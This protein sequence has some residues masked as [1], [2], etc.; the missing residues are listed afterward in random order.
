MIILVHMYLVLQFRV[1]D[2]SPVSITVSTEANRSRSLTT[3]ISRQNEYSYSKVTSMSQ[4]KKSLKKL[5]YNL[6]EWHKNRKV[7]QMLMGKVQ[8]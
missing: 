2:I 6:N 8:I 5:L 1:M 7:V 3:Q 4:E